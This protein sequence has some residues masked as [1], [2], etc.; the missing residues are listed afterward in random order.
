MLHPPL[1]DM[2]PLIRGIITVSIL[3]IAAK[4]F[5]GVFR[6]LKLPPVLGELFA[7]IL[8]GPYALGGGIIIFGEPLVVINE[9]VE[10]FAEIGA[11]LLLL[12]AGIEL[13]L[14]SLRASGMIAALIATGGGILP[15]LL[16][17]YFYLTT[18]SSEAVA[19]IAGAA[20]VATS[21][22][23]SK[24]VLSDMG[25]LSTR[26]GATLMSAAVLD[27]IV[28]IVVLGVV[29]S[30]ISGGSLDPLS[31]AW[32]TASFIV[33]WLIILGISVAIIPRFIEALEDFSGK[34][35]VKAIA[36]SAGL[37]TASVTGA[38]GLS[39]LVG[40]Y[41]AGLAIGE[42]KWREEIMELVSDL[43]AIFGS[44]FFAYLGTL[45]DL[46]VMS[47][48][49]VV[50]IILILTA[51]AMA[52]KFVGAAI[53]SLLSLSLRE[54]VGLG[55]GMMPRGELGLII[56]SI[57][58]TT[59]ALGSEAYAEIVGMVALTTLLSPLILERVCRRGMG[60]D[61]SGIGGGEEV[62]SN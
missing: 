34:G 30:A 35:A 6:G 53:P 25:L 37:G 58:I 55:V 21:I 62:Q 16:A 9:Y 26:M 41:A 51:L 29:V 11:I 27:D 18:G 2:E 42:S 48:P 49:K 3:I 61:R 19:L 23:I 28:G 14:E 46:R 17:Y 36:I 1:E 33:I 32:K 54:A 44:I 56:A 38:L 13:G 8:L 12:A 24:R 47:D 15:F 45:L 4:L 43:E 10:G 20:F 50:S 40:A 7:G 59:G 22:A 39:P 31:I 52:G 57:G 60:D 5:S